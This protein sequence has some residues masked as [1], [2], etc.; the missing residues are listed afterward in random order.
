MKDRHG[1][2]KSLKFTLEELNK[3]FEGGH[4]PMEMPRSEQIKIQQDIDALHT[5]WSSTCVRAKKEYSKLSLA[6]QNTNIRGVSPLSQSSSC[7]SRH[8]TPENYD[9]ISS[10]LG[11]KMVNG[12]DLHVPACSMSSSDSTLPDKNA[13]FDSLL[14][15]LKRQA[16]QQVE[17]LNNELDMLSKV[18]R[19]P[20]LP[21]P[22]VLSNSHKSLSR[23]LNN[24]PPLSNQDATTSINRQNRGTVN[25][26][27]KA[28][29]PT[30]TPPPPPKP[31][32]KK[33]PLQPNNSNPSLPPIQKEMR[34]SH[35][36]VQIR[37]LTEIESDQCRLAKK[38]KD[39]EGMLKRTESIILSSFPCELQSE[40]IQ[41]KLTG[42]KVGYFFLQLHIIMKWMW[43]VFELINVACFF[44][45]I[46]IFSSFDNRLCMECY[47]SEMYILM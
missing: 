47:L 44:P 27:A 35:S 11:N 17:S 42:V 38:L 3:H 31:A 2:I 6:L 36:L 5:K 43:Y 12:N 4:S 24:Q 20:P 15:S 21:K 9:E 23:S 14:D 30:H 13:I 7:D 25:G 41:G 29:T 37:P 18:H 46:C 33:P 22:S 19:P 10:G 26:T 32:R 34:K 8:T 45:I 1:V 16:D 40:N 28:S 39:T